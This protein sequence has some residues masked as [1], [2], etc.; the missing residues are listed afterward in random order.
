MN[1]THLFNSARSAF[2]ASFLIFALGVISFFAFEP[3]I[4]R[5]ASDVFLVTQSITDETSFMASTTDVTLSPSISGL[6]GGTSSGTT[7]VRVLSNNNTGY[8]MTLAFSNTVAMQ[9]NA[10]GGSIPN[11]TPASTTVPDFTFSVGANTAEFAYTVSASSTS[12]LDTTFRNNGTL[13]NNASGGDTAFSCWFN[14]STTPEI[15]VNRGTSTPASGAT[16]SIAFRLQ[17][18]SNPSP[19][20]PEDTYTATATLTAVNN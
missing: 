4:G 17:V 19:A 11:Y 6:T 8:N 18:T 10:F 13:C 16:T 9:G 1:S 3:S 2:I 15:I 7:T 20:I 5:T 14:P 12:D